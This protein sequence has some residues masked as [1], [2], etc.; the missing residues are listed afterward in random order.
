MTTDTSALPGRFLTAEWRDLVMLNYE[1]DPAALRPL[2]PAGTELDAWGGTTYVSMVGFNFLDTRV[3]GIPIPFH[4]DFEEVNL[5]F[6]VRRRGPEGW[7][8]GVVFVREIVPRWAIATVARVIYNE[9]YA[10][11]PMRHRIEESAGGREVEYGWKHR[12]R[13]CSI[14]ATT[15]GEPRALEPGSEAEFITE[16]Y[17]G[18]AAQ[19]GGGTVEYRVEHPSWRVWKAETHALDVDAATLYGP[20]FG[21]SLAAAPRSA[22]VA[23]GSP[24]VVRRGV[25]V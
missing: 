8:R 20:A 11:M 7:R 14:R 2:V 19:R 5:R 3:L 10:A 4:R 18:Y 12:G 17:W 23:E 13:W 9:Q 1:A 16:H 22:F 15:R 25:R 6:Y 24:V 21:A